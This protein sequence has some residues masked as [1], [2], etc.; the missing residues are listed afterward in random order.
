MSDAAWLIAVLAGVVAASAIIAWALTGRVLRWVCARRVLAQPEAR[1]SHT[2]PTPVGG[3]L[4]VMAVTLTAGFLVSL[5]FARIDWAALT[6]AAAALTLLSWVD[7]R[8]GLSP[9]IRLLA[10]GAAVA[11]VLALLPPTALAFQGLLPLWVDRILLFVAWL[12]FVNL[13][14]FI[15]GID[16]ITGTVTA[17]IGLGII[18]VL[19][20]GPGIG[21][22]DEDAAVL[23]QAASI[24]GAALGFLVWNWHPARIFL[25]DTGSIPLGYCIGGLLILLAVAGQWAAALILPGYSLGD[26]TVTV[27]QRLL[28]GARIWRPHRQHFYQRAVLRGLSHAA[29][30]RRVL[31]VQAVLAGLAVGTTALPDTGQMALVAIAAALVLA[32]LRWLAPF[33]EAAQR[34]RPRETQSS[35]TA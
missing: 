9:L 6:L 24:G 27:L 10:Q 19:F 34:E 4:A 5:G 16:G 17:M 35:P 1:S 30:S 15:D 7:D 3:G 14:N 25:G 12:W 21:S 23:L 22:A 11:A 32:T 33:R 28:R 13:Y 8:R 26:A 2:A 29:V 20:A 18:V 31:L